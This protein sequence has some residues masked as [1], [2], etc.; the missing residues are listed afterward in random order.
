MKKWLAII[1]ALVLAFAFIG[2][3]FGG[4]DEEEDDIQSF[5]E[6]D[7]GEEVATEIVDE[8]ITEDQELEEDDAPVKACEEG[9]SDGYNTVMIKDFPENP[10][11]IDCNTNPGADIDAVCLYGPDGTEKGCAATVELED[12]EPVC[13]ENHKD[14]AT[15]VLGPPDGIVDPDSGTYEGYYSLNGGAIVITFDGNSE[16]LCGDSVLIV[17]MFNPELAGSEEN[18]SGFYGKD[19]DMW[20]DPEY[21]DQT[22]ETSGEAEIDVIWYW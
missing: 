11:L 21:V 18:Y 2:C 13:D 5:E 14:D 7:D 15:K 20:A 4:G 8:E 17:E 10:T 12:I 1:A 6:I 19:A 9:A 16:R 3:D 22:D